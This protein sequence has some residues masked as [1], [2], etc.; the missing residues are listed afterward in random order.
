MVF[1]LKIKPFELNNFRV[2]YIKWYGGIS[3]KNLIKILFYTFLIHFG[4]DFN[5]IFSFWQS[6]TF[7]GYGL[8][9]KVAQLDKKFNLIYILQAGLWMS[10]TSVS[11]II[12]NVKSKQM[13]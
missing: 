3:L 11:V 2:H 13:T 12:L 5:F 9:S 7:W 6:N 4:S 10:S 1:S 8:N